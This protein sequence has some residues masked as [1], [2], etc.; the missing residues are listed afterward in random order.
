MANKVGIKERTPRITGKQICRDNHPSSS[1]IDYYKKALTI[2]VLDHVNN[3][4][5]TR[6]N[7][8]TL[9]SYKGLVVVPAYM[10]SLICKVGSLYSWKDEFRAF[11]SFYEDDL[12]NP[13][14]LEAEMELW[15]KYLVDYKGS[16]PDSVTATLKSVDFV[17]FENIKICLRIL[18]T[19]PVT[20][21]EC[22]RSFS[23]IHR[24]KNYN[25]ST[26]LEEQL[27]G[28]ALM[29]VHKEIEPDT[30]IVLNKVSAG[31]R[32]LELI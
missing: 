22:E 6:F 31:N 7:S 13:I 16:R 4:L 19:L 18:G 32:R 25:R 12:P 30:N 17:A 28:L 29:H 8:Q 21:C 20:S 27:N 14:A 3:E 1:T 10:F 9:I 23:A 15:E 24:F 5:K 2:P 11:T 26:M